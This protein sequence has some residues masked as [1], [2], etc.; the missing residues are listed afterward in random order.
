[1]EQTL[2]QFNLRGEQV[3]LICLSSLLGEGAQTPCEASRVLIVR[4]ERLCFGFAVSRVDAID[5]FNQFDPAML[6][7]GWQANTG[8]GI[9]VNDRVRSLV[10]VGSQERS[11]RATLLDLQGLARQLECNV[12]ERVAAR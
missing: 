1:R 12:A 2:G 7:Q 4:G 8:K 11:W 9:S 6:E 10:S 5:A 3:P